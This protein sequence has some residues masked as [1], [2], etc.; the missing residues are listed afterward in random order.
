MEIKIKFNLGSKVTGINIEHKIVA[1]EVGKIAVS[2]K[3]N[4]TEVEYY[5]SDGKGGYDFRC[6][7]EKYCF[8]T[9]AD[10]LAYIKGDQS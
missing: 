6:F 4:G 9:E 3:A 5:P 7:N 10:A 8:P 1:F 2:V